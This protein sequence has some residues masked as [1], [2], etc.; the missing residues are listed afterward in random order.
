VLGGKPGQSFSGTNSE[1]REDGGRSEAFEISDDVNDAVTAPIIALKNTS[2]RVT[3][4]EHVQTVAALRDKRFMRNLLLTG[5]S[6]LQMARVLRQLRRRD[7]PLPF[8]SNSQLFFLIHY[9]R[10]RRYA[11]HQKHICADR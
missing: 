2:Q 10:I 7:I 4:V 3:V 5:E 6:P 1:A 9:Q 8:I 11:V